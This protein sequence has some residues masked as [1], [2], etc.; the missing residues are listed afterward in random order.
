MRANFTYLIIDLGSIL[1]PFIFSF[2]PKIQFQKQWKN[3]WP[4]ITLTALLFIAWDMYFT[5]Q[6]IW[7]FNERYITGWKIYNLPI[8]ELLF[9]ICIP[10]ASMFTYQCFEIF[11]LN[12]TWFANNWASALLSGMLLITGIY[13]HNK[14]YTCVTGIALSVS[15]IYIGLIK[16]PDW[17]HGFYLMFTVILIPFFIVN[18][19]LTGT[20]LD[21]P[22]V[23]YNDSENSGVRLL[24]IPVE[25]VFYGMLLLLLTT[26]FFEHF[27]KAI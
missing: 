10:Y 5:A 14:A 26:F 8:E 15:I 6:G 27:K 23:W 7:G 25:D 17:L 13:M 16:K 11:K 2:H 9:F 3:L 12:V 24:T 4:A 1:V 21:E 19:L 20:C 18:G 22:I